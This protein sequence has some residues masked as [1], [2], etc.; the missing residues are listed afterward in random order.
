MEILIICLTVIALLAAILIFKKVKDHLKAAESEMHDTEGNKI[1]ISYN[2]LSTQQIQFELIPDT[3]NVDDVRLVEIKDK[4]VINHFTNL[5]PESLKVL[6]NVGS[7]K[8]YKDAVKTGGELYQ[9]IIPKGSVL[10][11][12]RDM[13]GAVRGSH[14]IAGR[15]KGNANWMPANSIADKMT[16]VNVTNAVMSVGAMVVGQY[17]MEQI[18]A[19]LKE[20]NN[21][22][23]KIV[24]FQ[25]NEYRSKVFALV[26]QVQKT[27]HFQVDILENEELKI[28]ELSNLDNR[29]QMCIEL[30]GQANLTIDGFSKNES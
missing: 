4:R 15:I 10:N 5:V 27:A 28:R 18:N 16:R 7:A 23:T 29:E 19:E 20:I 25:D 30:L 14:R 3:L 6:T 12:S 8:Q 11:K 9:A 22:I 13:A 2:S 21:G 26:T 24:D 17:Y 1:V